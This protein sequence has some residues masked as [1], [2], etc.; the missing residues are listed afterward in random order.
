MKS[1]QPG[2]LQAVPPQARHVFFSPCDGVPL[3]ELR[4]A[5]GRLAALA[6]GQSVVVG[7]GPQLVAVL[8]AT[9]PGLVEF[10][11]LSGH[12]VKVPSTPAALWCWLRGD[13]RGDLLQLTRRVEKALAPALRA[14]HVVESFRHR[15]GP[16]GHG[17][18]LTG[19]EDGTENPS[20]DAAEAAAL[21][22]GQGAGLDGSS[23][24]ALQ[25]W[26]HDFDAFD[27]LASQDQD[28]HMGRRRSDNE[29]LLDAPTSA[30]VKRTA[31]ESFDPP[32]FMLRRSMPWLMG[33]RAGLMFV[34]FG[35]SYAA[36]EAQMRRMAGCEDGIVD[37]MFRIS[38]PI[39]G[40]YLWCPPVEGGRLDLRQLGL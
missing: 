36:F 34:A 20:G 24:V 35:R 22:Q 2:I 23:Y 6:D 12:G 27:A 13:D 15:Q 16:N 3:D 5:L 7:I 11:D 14:G 26:V 4:Q 8:G 39:S 9:V 21:V 32:A 29:E 33:S 25:Q 17:L 10:P 28:K 37:A 40:S 1:A 18:D 30:H 19:Y 31:Q 38:E